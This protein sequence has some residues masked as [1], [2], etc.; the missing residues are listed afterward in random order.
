MLKEICQQT[1]SQKEDKEKLFVVGAK[2]IPID[3]L[4]ELLKEWKKH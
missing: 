4:N 3:Y 2:Y 1:L